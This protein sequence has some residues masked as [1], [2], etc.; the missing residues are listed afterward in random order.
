[1]QYERVILELLERVA[2][3]ENEVATFK[4]GGA[5][6]SKPLDGDGFSPRIRFCKAYAEE[7]GMVTN[8]RDATKYMLDGIHYGKGKLVL[9]VVQKYVKEHP[10]ITAEKLM[11]T[12]DKS[13]QGSLGVVRTLDDAKRS[14]AEYERRFFAADGNL[15]R[16][17]TDVC[18]VCSQW[19]IFNINRLVT[20]A[21][22]LGIDV[23]VMQ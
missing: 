1:M 20:R 21:K 12:F 9:A 15:I 16:T 11:A 3:L 22:Q 17:A 8:S 6:V 14:Y 19:G 2:K 4:E 18:V 10:D 23:T 13:L 7:P 5:L